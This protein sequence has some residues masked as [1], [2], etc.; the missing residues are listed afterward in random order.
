MTIFYE[1]KNGK[2]IRWTQSEQQAVLEKMQEQCTDEDLVATED[3]D[4]YLRSEVPEIPE[5]QKAVCPGLCGLWN[6]LLL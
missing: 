5:K 4:Y 1:K 2:I 6:H 3:G